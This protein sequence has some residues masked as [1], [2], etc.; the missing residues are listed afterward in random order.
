[1]DIS[2]ELRAARRRAGLTQTALARAAGTSQATVSQYEAGRKTPT[3]DTLERLLAATGHE[4]RVGGAVR[5]TR[6][7]TAAELE[8]AGRDLGRVVELAALL[9]TRHEPALTFPR[10]P[11]RRIVGPHA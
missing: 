3:F 4:I 1:M 8:R 9:P 10:L 6:R 7:P 5:P 11:T 2:T